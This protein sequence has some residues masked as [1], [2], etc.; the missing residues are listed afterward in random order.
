MA[1]EPGLEA[2]RDAAA[3]RLDPVHAAATLLLTGGLALCAPSPFF[4]SSMLRLQAAM[5]AAWFG[6]LGFS[7]DVG[8]ACQVNLGGKMELAAIMGCLSL[9]SVKLQL[10]LYDEMKWSS[11]CSPHSSCLK[12]AKRI[13]KS[14][15][16]RG[17]EK[18]N[19]SQF[20]R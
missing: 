1:G 20:G 3:L 6:T 4:Q 15:C 10:K 18:G 16:V 12:G 5:P 2:C 13:S 7:V 19:V 17:G 9:Y 8:E 11:N 14:V